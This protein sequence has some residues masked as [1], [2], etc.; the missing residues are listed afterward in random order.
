MI[1]NPS[2]GLPTGP[3]I[4][5][6][7]GWEVLIFGGGIES[8]TARLQLQAVQIWQRSCRPDGSSKFRMS[9]SLVY[10]LLFHSILVYSIV[11][12]PVLFHFTLHHILSHHIALQTK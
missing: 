4:D 11:F 6:Q 1:L 3:D 5:D 12:H 10:S 2:K 7:G 9:F 8:A